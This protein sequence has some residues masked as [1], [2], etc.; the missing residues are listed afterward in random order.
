MLGDT[1]QAN[2]PGATSA[3]AREHLSAGWPQSCSHLTDENLSVNLETIAL[4]RGK[5]SSEAVHTAPVSCSLLGKQWAPRDDN[6]RV[7]AALHGT[8]HTSASAQRPHL[9]H[10]GRVRG[11]RGGGKAPG[12][13]DVSSCPCCSSRTTATPRHAPSPLPSPARLPSWSLGLPAPRAWPH[14]P[15]Q[16][17]RA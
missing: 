4:E 13:G 15:H 6:R 2:A 3:H 7:P 9:L 17:Q 8:T 10:D 11:G 16:S 12:G 5:L 14:A 1:L